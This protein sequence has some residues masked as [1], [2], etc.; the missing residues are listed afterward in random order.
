MDIETQH[1]IIASAI[2]ASMIALVASLRHAPSGTPLHAI[3]RQSVEENLQTV[4]LLYFEGGHP[5]EQ[6]FRRICKRV[7]ER[8]FAGLDYLEKNP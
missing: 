7:L 4:S 6:E 1:N 3:D 5:D 8:F 2:A